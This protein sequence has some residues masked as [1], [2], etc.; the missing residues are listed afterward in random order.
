MCILVYILHLNM[1]SLC[2]HYFILGKSM[3]ISLSLYC[4][5]NILGQELTFYSFQN[6][7]NQQCVFGRAAHRQH[8]QTP[9][10]AIQEHFHVICIKGAGKT[11]MRPKVLFALLTCSS[12][13]LEKFNPLS[14]RIP[15]SS[16]SEV[17][18]I[19]LPMFL[20]VL[21]CRYVLSYFAPDEALYIYLH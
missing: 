12:T 10:V 2:L 1:S 18:N 3:H 7:L 20:A 17:P 14:P 21:C 9:G 16:T 11:F 8:C 15:R 19:T 6:T 5:Q 4:S 13:C